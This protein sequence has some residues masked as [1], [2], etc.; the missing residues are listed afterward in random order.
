MEEVSK[1]C[2]LLTRKVG[3][4]RRALLLPANFPLSAL[5]L[6]AFLPAPSGEF[7]LAGWTTTQQ[8][9]ED[10]GF[11]TGSPSRRAIFERK[12]MVRFVMQGTDVWRRK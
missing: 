3:F 5:V 12:V 8:A 10:G 7:H 4:A 9:R 6:F 2:K 11:H 1:L